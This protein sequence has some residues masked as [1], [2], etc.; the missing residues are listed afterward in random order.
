MR[1]IMLAIWAIVPEKTLITKRTKK[2][3]NQASSKDIS[4]A[5]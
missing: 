5:L 2:E 1:R 4:T 3:Y